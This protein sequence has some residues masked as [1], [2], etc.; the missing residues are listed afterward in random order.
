VRP[1]SPEHLQLQTNQDAFTRPF[2]LDRPS[3]LDLPI[4]HVGLR[5]P[6][7]DPRQRPHANTINSVGD[8][9]PLSRIDAGV[10]AFHCVRMM[11]DTAKMPARGLS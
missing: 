9:S 6:A 4:C 3:A 8:A 5:R 2:V 10:G 7:P 11:W 1:P